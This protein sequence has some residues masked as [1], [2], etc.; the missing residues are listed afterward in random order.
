MI[1]VSALSFTQCVDTVGRATGRASGLE[2]LLQKLFCFGDATQLAVTL[3]RRLVN[4][5]R[6]STVRN[7]TNI[8]LHK[9]GQVS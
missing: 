5:K 6:S 7:I 1:G 9:I 8:T 4:G 3:E 2:K